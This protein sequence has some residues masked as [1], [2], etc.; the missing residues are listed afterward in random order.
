MTDTTKNSPD[1]MRAELEA[2][3][4]KAPKAAAQQP[5][6]ASRVSEQER[7]G[8]HQGRGMDETERFER[9]PMDA[10]APPS[11]LQLPPNDPQYVYRWIA[12]YVNGSLVPNRL[13]RARQQGYEFVRVDQLPPDFYVDEDVKGDGLARN[14]GLIMAR[15]PRKFADQ[16][17]RYYDR[18]SQTALNG[19]N[20]LQGIAGK[21]TVE[22]DRGTRTLDGRVAGD[23]L[24]QL[25]QR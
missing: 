8:A 23:A 19:A 3:A 2:A 24:R 17:R 1:P 18:Q 11:T 6:P 9:A 13:N 12:E 21:N 14:G 15:L 22:E 16:R 5:D 20:Q 4:K 10:W 7:A 25:A